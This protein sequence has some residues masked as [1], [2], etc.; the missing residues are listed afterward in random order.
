MLMLFLKDTKVEGL[1]H[2]TPIIISIPP[3]NFKKPNVF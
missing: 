2:F 3:K 1:T